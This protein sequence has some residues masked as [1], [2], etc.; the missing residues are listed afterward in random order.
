MILALNRALPSALIGMADMLAL[1]NLSQEHLPDKHLADNNGPKA[2]E[3]WRPKVVIASIDGNPVVDGQGRAF[4]P[5]CGLG[6]IETCDGV[7]N[8]GLCQKQMVYLPN[9]Y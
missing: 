4:T 9:H 5:D 1:A 8:L 6:D 7:L 2:P 3:P